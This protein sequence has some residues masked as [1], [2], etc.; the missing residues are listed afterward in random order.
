M[1]VCETDPQR[2]SSTQTLLGLTCV[3]SSSTWNNE[4]RELWSELTCD[5]FMNESH[6]LIVYESFSCDEG[7]GGEVETFL[8]SNNVFLQGEVMKF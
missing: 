4:P 2:I 3:K 8:D 6:S 5:D 1:F 7:W